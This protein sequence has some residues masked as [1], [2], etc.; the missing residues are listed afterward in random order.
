VTRL[1]ML[2][3]SLRGPALEYY[4]DLPEEDRTNYRSLIRCFHNRFGREDLPITKRFELQEVQQNPDE[5]LDAFAERVMRL[6]HGAYADLYMAKEAIEAVAVGVMLT[7]CVDAT[8]A[9][10]VMNQNPKTM[11]QA[12]WMLQTAVTTNRVFE[13]REERRTPRET[14]VRFA[15]SPDAHVRVASVREA[16]DDLRWMKKQLQVMQEEM[17]E[18]KEL[19]KA[20]LR[21]EG[22]SNPKPQV[23]CYECGAIG[24]YARECTRRGPLPNQGRESPRSEMSCSSSPAVRK[25][26][27]SPSPAPRLR[28]MV[29]V[30][31]FADG[32]RGRRQRCPPVEVRLPLTPDLRRG[33][34]VMG[35][36]DLTFGAWRPPETDEAESYVDALQRNLQEAHE[37]TRKK[38]MRAGRRSRRP[39]HFAD[40]H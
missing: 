32:P 30:E 15:Q 21:A 31:A 6:T 4:A 13:K 27:R 10:S 37:M 35:P 28:R 16:D 22:G 19:V 18:L 20:N 9:A 12:L 8:A 2:L 23:K 36:A 25:E 3:L 39:A 5:N 34:E 40:Y 7:G 24:H 17:Q 14:R 1:E 11:Q 38:T 33:R 29:A 26:P